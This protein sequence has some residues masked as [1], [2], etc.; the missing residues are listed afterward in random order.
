MTWILDC[1]GKDKST[2]VVEKQCYFRRVIFI[3][4]KGIVMSVCTLQYGVVDSAFHGERR[5][6]QNKEVST[7]HVC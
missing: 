6:M 7:S 3:F 2:F 5:N 1:C 4:L